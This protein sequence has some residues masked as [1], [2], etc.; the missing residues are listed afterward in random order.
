ML[1]ALTGRSSVAADTALHNCHAVINLF[2]PYDPLAYRLDHLVNGGQ[3]F[4]PE[5][6]EHHRGRKRIHLGADVALG[7][8]LDAPQS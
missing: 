1:A 2:H 6:I 3:H 4:E 5:L 7:T 8:V